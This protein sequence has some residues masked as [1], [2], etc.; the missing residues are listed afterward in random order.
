MLGFSVQQRLGILLKYSENLE[1]SS[2]LGAALKFW[3]QAL[4]VVQAYD[5]A[6]VTYRDMLRRADA[7]MARVIDGY[8]A[9]VHAAEQSLLAVAATLRTSFGDDLIIRK[10]TAEVL[11][12]LRREKLAVMRTRIVGI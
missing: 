3:E 10:K 1:E 12:E 4:V 5:N 8:A 11:I 2:K 7:S 9:Q 6:Y